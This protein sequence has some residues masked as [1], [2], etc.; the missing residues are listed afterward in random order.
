[1]KLS[2]CIPISDMVNGDFF[3]SRL[4]NSITQQ[5]FRDF[6]VI[7]TKQG[8]AA[9]NTN[10]SMRLAKGELIKI[11]HMD[12]YFAH[13]DALQAII[14][15]FK[16]NWLVTASMTELGNANFPVYDENKNTIGAPSVLTIR[17]GLDIYFDESLEWLFDLEFY[18]RLYAKYG[19]PVIID[20]INVLIG[21]HA[22]QAT[23][24]LSAE[25]KNAEESN[26]IK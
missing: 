6:E 19:E 17:N 23:N 22:D 24:K 9:E 4:I 5:S 18:R 25:I 3:L 8:K 21:I 13:K 2:I 20:D 1:M 15:A 14:D 7:I 10:A 16:G 12:D 26:L 11:M